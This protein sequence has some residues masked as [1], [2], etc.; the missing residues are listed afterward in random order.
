MTELESVVVNDSEQ[1]G[2]L[3]KARMIM[4]SAINSNPNSSPSWIAAARIE[5]FDG[6]LEAA[7][8]LIAQ[9][10]EKCPDN[11]DIWLEAARLEKPEKQKAVLAKA[12][13]SIP[14]S[15]K[16]WLRCLIQVRGMPSRDRQRS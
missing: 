8:N 2:D 5:E 4:K 6:K 12:I 7:R 10:L 14:S 13:S 1:I 16:L 15:V 11:E 3:K 9:G